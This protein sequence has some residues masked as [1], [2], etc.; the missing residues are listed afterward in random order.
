MKTLRNVAL[1][2]VMACLLTLAGWAQPTEVAGSGVLHAPVVHK[3]EPPNWWVNYTPELTLLLTGENLFGARVKSAS[4]SVSVLGSEGSANGHYLF[5]RLKI[6]SLSLRPEIVQL[7][8]N[9]A[10]GSNV[11]SIATAASRRLAR[12][13]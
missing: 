3:I 1:S 9:S 13:L 12:A 5:V 2:L 7:R 10:S 4:K 8:L 6:S 11:H